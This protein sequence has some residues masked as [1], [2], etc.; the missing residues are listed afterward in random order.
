MPPIETLASPAPVTA[1][2]AFSTLSRV[3]ATVPV[4]PALLVVRLPAA[5]RYASWPPIVILPVASA[6]NVVEAEPA[7]L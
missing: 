1:A 3:A 4:P 6:W 5:S 2:A 7:L